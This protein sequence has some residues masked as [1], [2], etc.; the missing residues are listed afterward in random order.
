MKQN[1]WSIL[2][3]VIAITYIVISIIWYLIMFIDYDKAINTILLGILI[4]A[5]SWLYNQTRRLRNETDAI[6]EKLDDI[7]YELNQGGK[8][9]WQS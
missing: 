2:G 8:T 5:V 6:G 9:K 1:N 4:F 3:Y 7:Q